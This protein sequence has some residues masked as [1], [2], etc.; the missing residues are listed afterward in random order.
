MWIIPFIGGIGQNVSACEL[1]T[2]GQLLSHHPQQRQT[3]LS[4]SCLTSWIL[5][6]IYYWPLNF[7]ITV[8]LGTLLWEWAKGF[9]NDIFSTPT[10]LMYVSLTFRLDDRILTQYFGSQVS[11]VHDWLS[12]ATLA[13]ISFFIQFLIIWTIYSGIHQLAWVYSNTGWCYGLSENVDM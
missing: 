1:E 7:H 2:H 6:S 5:L 11:A 10:V 4:N 9:I 3:R 13:D 8:A 12:S